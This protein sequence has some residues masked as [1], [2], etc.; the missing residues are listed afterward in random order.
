[1]NTIGG[2]E[3]PAPSAYLSCLLVYGGEGFGMIN[4]IVLSSLFGLQDNQQSPKM[5]YPIFFKNV[6]ACVESGES[7]VFWVYLGS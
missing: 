7:D 3:D 2:W 5:W 1:M 6:Q 4:G